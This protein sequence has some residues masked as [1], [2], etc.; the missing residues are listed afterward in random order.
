MPAASNGAVSAG[1]VKPVAVKSGRH[2]GLAALLLL[3]LALRGAWALRQSNDPAS[4]SELPDQQEY[5][6]IGQ[7]LLAGRG[8]RFTDPRFG[9]TVWA[10]RTPGYPWLIA[11]CGA[12]LR[13][14]RLAQ[15]LLDTSTVLAVY[16]MAGR[17]LPPG[18]CLFAAAWVAFNPL[19]ISFSGLIL[20]ETLFIAMLAWG[21][22]LLTEKSAPRILAGAAALAVSVLVR[23]SALLLPAFLALVARPK[24]I[25]TAIACLGMTLLALFPWALRNEILL[26]H[27]IWTST[28]SGITKYDGFNPRA[29]GGSNQSFVR[30]MP[31]LS[32]MN[33]IQR[34]QYLDGLA[35]QFIEEHPWRCVQLTVAKLGRLWSP[36]P[37]S[38]QFGSN[39]L[40]VA[41]ELIYSAPFFMLTLVGLAGSAISRWGKL[42]LLMPA[43]YF[44]VVHG[45]SV[46]SLRYRLPAEP[47]M[48]VVAAGAFGRKHG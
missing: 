20:S 17:W 32:Q 47:L 31:Q 46:S 8:L 39:R 14:I 48:A 30:D 12:N 19:L 34:S 13:A 44:S 40:Y 16:L 24:A 37:L 36:I 27:W 45:L 5:F 21:A 1:A 41:V 28:N 2:V 3:A 26:H 18:R 25:P 33:E 10:Y 7:N 35:N 15:A 42:F 43:L 4:L 29:D 11:A 38:Q 22:V 9:Q 23:P 6:Q